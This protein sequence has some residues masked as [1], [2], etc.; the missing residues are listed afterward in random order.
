MFELVEDMGGT[1]LVERRILSAY[2]VLLKLDEKE[3][4]GRSLTYK[5]SSKRP[6]ME[7]GG[8]P[9]EIKN[10]ALEERQEHTETC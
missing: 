10:I 2:I 1:N 9:T 7:P 6:R 8:T 3:S 4:L 5:I